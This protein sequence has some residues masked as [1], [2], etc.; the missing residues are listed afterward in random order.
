MK[1]KMYEKKISE[2]TVDMVR[3]SMYLHLYF[4]QMLSV[5]KHTMQCSLRLG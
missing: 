2:N 3:Q 4:K 5:W 1:W